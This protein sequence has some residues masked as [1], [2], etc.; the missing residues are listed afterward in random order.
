MNKTKENQVRADKIYVIII[1]Y[2]DRS[3]LEYCNGRIIILTSYSI[4]SASRSARHQQVAKINTQARYEYIVTDR[5]RNDKNYTP[6]ALFLQTISYQTLAGHASRRGILG[7]THARARTHTHTHTLLS[8]SSFILSLSL[9]FSLSLSLTQSVCL[10]VS[11]SACLLLSISC[12]LMR[13][14][15]CQLDVL[16]KEIAM[17]CEFPRSRNR[18]PLVITDYS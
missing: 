9:S 1:I 6:W 8:L 18:E 17:I 15:N 10:S 14:N 5:T 11:L 16:Y 3:F 2:T 12:L 7:L 13:N 4:L